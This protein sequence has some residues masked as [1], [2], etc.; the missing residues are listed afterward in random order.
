QRLTVD[1][2]RCAGHG[3]CAH[4]VPE[5]VQLDG[6]GYPD[7]LD[8]PVPPWLASQA[9]QAVEMCPAL[10][11]RLTPV[12]ERKGRGAVFPTSDAGAPDERGGCGEGARQGRGGKAAPS[13]GPRAS[14]PGKHSDRGPGGHRGVDRPARR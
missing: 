12:S 7:F 1:W 10:A 6:Q 11:L 9:S 2:T 4:L 14:E 5:L 8:M 13:G 3:L